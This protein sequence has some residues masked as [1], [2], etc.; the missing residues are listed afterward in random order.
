MSTDEDYWVTITAGWSREPGYYWWRDY[1]GGEPEITEVR[2]KRPDHKLFDSSC[3]PEIHFIFSFG[4]GSQCNMDLDYV[5]SRYDGVA[6]ISA[7]RIK[8]PKDES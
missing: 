8:P 7:E 5:L 2:M 4:Y 3:P 6:Q 1:P